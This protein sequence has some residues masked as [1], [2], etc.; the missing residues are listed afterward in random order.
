M[1]ITRKWI[2]RYPKPCCGNDGSSGCWVYYSGGRA[3]TRQ[4]LWVGVF[5]ARRTAYDESTACTRLFIAA[6]SISMVSKDNTSPFILN[7][8]QLCTGDSVRFPNLFARLGRGLE[9]LF[10][11]LG[12]DLGYTARLSPALL[13]IIYLKAEQIPSSKAEFRDFIIAMLARAVRI[14]RT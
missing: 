11:N 12:H 5:R 10:Q 14:L 13:S 9:H 3:V 8:F 2:S 4:Y 7:F 1:V 6:L